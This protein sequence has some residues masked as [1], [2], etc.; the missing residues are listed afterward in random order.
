M[1]YSRAM[2]NMSVISRVS[3]QDKL[4]TSGT[5][6]S[7]HP[8][9][10]SRFLWRWWYSDNRLQNV[11]AVKATVDS[12]I[13]AI[14]LCDADS[15]SNLIAQPDLVGTRLSEMLEKAIVGLQNLKE[16]YKDDIGVHSSLE[17]LITESSDFLAQRKPTTQRAN[18]N[19]SVAIE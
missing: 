1:D 18:L 14:A 8:P 3:Q 9:S 5:Y 17:R 13:T 11:E 16:T 10:N 19:V 6:F 4:V 12:A 2:H 15:T 7:I